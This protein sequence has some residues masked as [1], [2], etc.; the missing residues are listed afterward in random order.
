MTTEDA[1]LAGDTLKVHGQLH[2][3]GRSIP[4]DIDAAM[5]EQL[6]VRGRLVPREHQS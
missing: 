6:I 5:R 3:A 4:L 2:A 1:A